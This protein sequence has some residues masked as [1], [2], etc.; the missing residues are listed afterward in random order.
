MP[1]LILTDKY[2]LRSFKLAGHYA[3]DVSWGDGH[4][5]IYPFRDLRLICPCDAC[6]NAEPTEP[7]L[8][9]RTPI[10]IAREASLLRL[11]WED[12]HVSQLGPKLLRDRCRCAACIGEVGPVEA[13]LGVPRR[14]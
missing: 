2:E 7:D 3:L 1:L 10:E 4:G 8:A 12:D 6:S 9:A 11:V 5:S 14:S 13:F